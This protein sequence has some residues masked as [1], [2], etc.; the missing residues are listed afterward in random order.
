MALVCFAGPFVV[1]DKVKRCS[2]SSILN[3]LSTRECITAMLMTRFLRTQIRHV[4]GIND[5]AY[6]FQPSM[7]ESMA[8]NISTLN[9]T[10]ESL[11]CRQRTSINNRPGFKVCCPICEEGLI[12]ISTDDAT[13]DA[14]FIGESRSQEKF[15][16]SSCQLDI[17]ACCFT[18]LPYVACPSVDDFDES[19]LACK[20][21]ACGSLCSVE[22]MTHFMAEQQRIEYSW[23][24]RSGDNG[25]LC[26]FC[27][28]PL[29]PSL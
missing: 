28:V 24:P 9:E 18:L 17:E 6:S 19:S 23:L 21:S 14:T 7:S 4:A 22:R 20:C 15:H 8:R 10:V 26:L 16:C 5:S 29:F 3:F 1:L 27:S 13:S 2:E 11:V 12:F 25:C